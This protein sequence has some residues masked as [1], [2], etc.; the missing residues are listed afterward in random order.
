MIY[1]IL[2]ADKF[3]EKYKDVEVE[4]FDFDN[5]PLDPKE[6]AANLIETMIDGK[7]IGM[8]ATQVD[9]PYK[10]FAIGN[11]LE[12]EECSVIF[13]PTITNTSEEMVKMEEGC[14]SFPNLFLKIKRP[15]DIRMRMTD[16]NGE[17]ITEKFYGLTARIIQHEYDHLYGINFTQRVPR[18]YLDKAM[19][20]RKI[21]LRRG[22]EQKLMGV[23]K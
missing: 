8:A 5:P 6:L 11:P 16:M 12:P 20:K 23:K 14:I 4:D 15:S 1:D 17:T 7:G 3:I 10:V 13:N 19:K 2:S 22:K 21:E 18:F 9:I